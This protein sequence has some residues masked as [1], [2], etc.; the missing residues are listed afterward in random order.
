MIT[1][2]EV[3]IP[4][5]DFLNTVFS[6]L[7]VSFAIFWMV[8]GVNLLKRKEA[9]KPADPPVPSAEEK[10]LIEIRDLLAREKT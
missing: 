4:Y 7:I 5:G 3:L 2:P 9:E 6:F 1:K 10:L 8:K